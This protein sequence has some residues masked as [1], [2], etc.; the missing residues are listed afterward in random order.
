MRKGEGKQ[1]DGSDIYGDSEN[2]VVSG[3]VTSMGSEFST[4]EVERNP[5]FLKEVALIGRYQGLNQFRQMWDLDRL[6]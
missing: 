1:G 6:G 5:N 2:A 3:A 4:A